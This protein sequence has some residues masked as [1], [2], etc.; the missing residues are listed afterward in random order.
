[1]PVHANCQ[2]KSLRGWPGDYNEHGFQTKYQNT[3]KRL[4]SI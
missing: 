1:M 4:L 3:N 2:D